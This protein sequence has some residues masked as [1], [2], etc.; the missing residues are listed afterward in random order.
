MGNQPNYNSDA[1]NDGC[2][3]VRQGHIFPI[4]SDNLIEG[5]SIG[6]YEG[7]QDDSY[8]KIEAKLKGHRELVAKRQLRV[9]I[10]VVTFA[11]AIATLGSNEEYPICNEDSFIKTI[12]DFRWESPELFAQLV[13]VIQSVSM[14][15]KGKRKR[16]IKDQESRGAKLQKIEDSIANLDNAQG[17]AVL[18]LFLF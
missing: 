11:P 8:N 5:K 3:L 6:E 14:K 10:N 17:R 1:G 15:R 18:L 13:S 4:H 16:E 9:E 7:G 12:A 2:N